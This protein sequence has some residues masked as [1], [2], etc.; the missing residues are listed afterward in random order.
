MCT[1][2]YWSLKIFK[3]SYLQ[4]E[5]TRENYLCM[6]IHINLRFWIFYYCS[7]V[8]FSWKIIKKTIFFME[9]CFLLKI[10]LEI[11]GKKS[12]YFVMS[13]FATIIALMFWV[14]LS[15]QSFAFCLSL[16][17]WIHY[18]VIVSINWLLVVITCLKISILLNSHMF[19]M[20]VHVLWVPE[21]KQI[22]NVFL[23][24]ECSNTP[25][26]VSWCKIMHRNVYFTP[27]N[28]SS[29]C[30]VAEFPVQ[31]LLHGPFYDLQMS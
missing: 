29:S 11:I 22:S 16:L 6:K 3:N 24:Q 5:L 9:N 26:F 25:C 28:H 1:W 14:M 7:K 23:S 27:G 21:P 2:F 8:W 18:F 10:K 4:K 31:V 12:Q 30:G 20:G 15:V 17:L 13:P 19:S